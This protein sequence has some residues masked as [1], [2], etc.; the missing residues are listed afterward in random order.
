MKPVSTP[1]TPHFKLR[2][3]MSPTTVED[4]EYMTRVLYASAVGSLMYIMVCTRPNLSKVVS[5]ISRYMHDPEK[6]HWG[7]VKWVPRYIKGTIDV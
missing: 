4:C 6:G 2:A 7:A 1:L 5:I 3:S